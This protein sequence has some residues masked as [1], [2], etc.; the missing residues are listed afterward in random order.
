MQKSIGFN[1]FGTESITAMDISKDAE[2]IA[3]A[4]RKSK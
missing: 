3:L 1:V 4:G 2:Y